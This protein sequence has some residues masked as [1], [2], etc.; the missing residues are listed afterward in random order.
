MEGF[1]PYATLRFGRMDLTLKSAAELLQVGEEQ[2][3]HWISTQGLPARTVEGR[4]TIDRVAL[5][6]WAWK[7]KK[8]IRPSEVSGSGESWVP[9]LASALELGGIHEHLPGDDKNSVYRAFIDALPLP[10]KVDRGD[11][12]R[13]VVARESLCPTG[14]G[15]GLAIPHPRNPVVIHAD[16]PLLAIGFPERPIADFGAMDS[17]PVTALL[18][19][20]APTVR[21]HLRMLASLTAALRS[22]EVVRCLDERA[23]PTELIATLDRVDRA[24]T[25]AQNAAS[26]EVE[27][28]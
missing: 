7:N 27:R 25:A 11:L 17:K 13:V 5:L 14:I 9:M 6:E 24:S 22:A 10:S 16:Q 15:N 28:P 12:W 20:V 21:L 1:K 2:V 26:S 4:H 18:M 3:E 23:R 19:I 8:P